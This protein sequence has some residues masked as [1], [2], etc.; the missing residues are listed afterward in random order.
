MLS[1]FVS[2]LLHSIQSTGFVHQVEHV[3]FNDIISKQKSDYTSSERQKQKQH[4]YTVALLNFTSGQ[5]SL[6]LM[7][8]LINQSKLHVK[9]IDAI[10]HAYESG[11]FT[12]QIKFKQ[13]SLGNEMCSVHVRNINGINHK[14]AFQ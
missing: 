14:N 1:R 4:G 6:L 5:I 3:R 10:D 8:N 7:Q 11:S 2:K 13:H 9:G 12:S